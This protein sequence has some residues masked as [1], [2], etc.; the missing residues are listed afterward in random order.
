MIVCS[1]VDSWCVFWLCVSVVSVV[2]GAG[3]VRTSWCLRELCG[4]PWL[5]F[6]CP[7]ACVLFRRGCVPM[8]ILVVFASIGV[9]LG[10]GCVPVR[11]LVVF[12]SMGVYLGRGCVACLTVCLSWSCLCF[13]P[14]VS[15]STMFAWCAWILAGGVHVCVVFNLAQSQ[16]YYSKICQQIPLK[17]GIVDGK[18]ENQ[19]N[20]EV[21]LVVHF[22][23]TNQLCCTVHWR[24]RDLSRSLHTHTPHSLVRRKSFVN[25]LVCA[26]SCRWI[27]VIYHHWMNSE[28]RYRQSISILDVKSLDLRT[29]TRCS[30]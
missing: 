18:T 16:E 28:I 4:V 17:A 22:E 5:Y 2:L 12:A 1:T 14:V 20:L 26:T 9:Y 24:E 3:C 23:K 30:V 29:S 13:V 11:I 27:V 7:W 8:R 19:T 6:A 15:L 21:V 10:R 25:V